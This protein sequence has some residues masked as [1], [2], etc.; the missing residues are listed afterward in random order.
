VPSVDNVLKGLPKGTDGRCR[1][2]TIGSDVSNSLVAS[3]G[4]AKRTRPI[5]RDRVAEHV[6]ARIAG[7]ASSVPVDVT[8]DI[9]LTDLSAF[10]H[11]DWNGVRV[12]V[13]C[14]PGPGARDLV[15][16]VA[17][18]I[19]IRPA[20]NVLEWLDRVDS[21]RDYDMPDAPEVEDGPSLALSYHMYMF[22]HNGVITMR[23]L[24]KR[25]DL[26]RGVTEDGFD[27]TFRNDWGGTLRIQDLGDRRIR[28]ETK[29]FELTDPL[30][31]LGYL[32]IAVLGETRCDIH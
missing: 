10:E 26:F 1:Y 32:K 29:H 4:W 11:V 2:G 27:R 22:S 23:D 8:K 7:G 9:D 14:D 13:C 19:H 17:V 28:I 3:T 16:D 15:L 21:A 12:R 30:V 25:P 31:L 5:A 18:P 6:L 20:T 24:A